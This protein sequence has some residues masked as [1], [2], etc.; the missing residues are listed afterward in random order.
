MYIG[1]HVSLLHA[2]HSL[3]TPDLHRQLNLD[4]NALG[5][6]KKMM[7]LNCVRMNVLQRTRALFP[8]VDPE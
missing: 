1:M 5:V 6:N 3:L 2:Y 8:A 4:R 7:K